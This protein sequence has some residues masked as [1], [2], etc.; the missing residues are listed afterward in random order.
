M[1]S[2]LPRRLA[3]RY[4]TAR[5]RGP[6]AGIVLIVGGSYDTLQKKNLDYRSKGAR[7]DEMAILGRN[8]DQHTVKRFL[9]HYDVPA[10]V[11][12][13]RGVEDA[14]E[15]LLRSCQQQREDRLASVRARIGF[16]HSL[17]GDWDALSPWLKDESQVVV[18]RDLH[19]ALRP[20]PRFPPGR[21]FSSRALGRALRELCATIEHFNRRWQA[22]LRT[23]NVMTVNELRD[24]Y[25]RYYLLEK[26]CALRSARLARQGFRRLEPLTV[27][28]LALL[29]PPLPVPQMAE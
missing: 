26:E 23:V 22:F 27:D 19:T 9:A 24:G 28:D 7:V 29:L 10:Y 6:S 20:Q 21:S 8:D 12:R 11:R 17:A 18:L 14:Y 15:Q 25:N 5:H 16:L 13:A 2:S 3:Y 1:D 4:G